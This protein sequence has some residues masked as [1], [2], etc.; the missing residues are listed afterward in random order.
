MLKEK[1]DMNTDKNIWDNEPKNNDSAFSGEDL[2]NEN[3]LRDGTDYTDVVQ[4]YKNRKRNNIILA[5]VIIGVVVIGLLLGGKYL[6]DN[7]EAKKPEEPAV[8]EPIETDTDAP[9]DLESPAY[10]SPTN[11]VS[12]LLP[13]RPEVTN[14]EIKAFVENDTLQTSH[15]TILTIPN[16]SISSTVHECSVRKATDFCNVASIN[17]NDIAYNGYYLKDAAGS[18]FFEAG[19][20]FAPVEVQ[21]AAAAASLSINT[22]DGTETPVIVV[23]QQDGTGFMFIANDNDPASLLLLSETIAVS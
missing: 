3:L 12:Q 23:L 6:L 5:V 14:N 2:S 20:N 10:Q 4:T 9:L 22:L 17:L 1:V 15:G 11:P 8:S 13:D 21:G 7:P 19:K 18:R 16:S